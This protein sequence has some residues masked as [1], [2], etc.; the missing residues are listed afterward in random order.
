MRS[1]AARRRSSRRCRR[2]SCSRRR[3]DCRWRCAAALP[4]LPSSRSWRTSGVQRRRSMTPGAGRCV[5]PCSVRR[6]A[7]CRRARGEAGSR[8][9][10]AACHGEA[11]RRR[12]C[13]VVRA[14]R[15]SLSLACRRRV[16]VARVN[17]MRSCRR[18]RHGL[19]YRPHCCRRHGR[20]RSCGWGGPPPEPRAARKR[21]LS[22]A[23]WRGRCRADL[24]TWRCGAAF[25]CAG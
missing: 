1:R 11:R 6:P 19:R 8:A 16:R 15:V 20:R 24:L 9:R 17:V 10:K 5:V 22:A 13:A 12:S 25:A 2:W 23:A 21:R 18:R 14:A 4:R 3:G 7:C